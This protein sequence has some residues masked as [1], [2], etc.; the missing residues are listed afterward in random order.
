MKSDYRRCWNFNVAGRC[1][2]SRNALQ[3]CW[4]LPQTVSSL[5]CRI[6]RESSSC[7]GRLLRRTSQSTTSAAIMSKVT[8]TLNCRLTQWT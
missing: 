7:K 1:W 3:H 5:R 6:I 4:V 2:Q 8:M